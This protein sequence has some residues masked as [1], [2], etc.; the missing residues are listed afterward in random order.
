MWSYAIIDIL[1]QVGF[2]EKIYINNIGARSVEAT[3]SV[4]NILDGV[5]FTIGIYRRNL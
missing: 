3:E 1:N 4:K 5:L 2:V